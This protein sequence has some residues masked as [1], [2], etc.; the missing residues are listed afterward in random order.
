MTKTTNELIYRANK[1][2]YFKFK[3]IRNSGFE[4]KLLLND[5]GIK[6]FSLNQ[7]ITL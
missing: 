7:N 6:F 2:F 5:I 1:E 3:N 4:L